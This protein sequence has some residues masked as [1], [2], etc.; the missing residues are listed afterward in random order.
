MI[1]ILFGIWLH[2]LKQS[3]REFCGEQ[4]LFLPQPIKRFEKASKVSF[5]L[6]GE[7]EFKKKRKRGQA[8][9]GRPA[10][11]SAQPDSVVHFPSLLSPA[12]GGRLAP[13]DAGHVA[14]IRRRWTRRGRPAITWSE[15][16]PVPPGST[17]S[18]R[19]S[20]LLPLSLASVAAVAAPP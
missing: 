8:L 20:L 10:S 15:G 17:L 9:L 4:F 14:A 12:R 2:L 19:S 1:Q 3:C 6:F 7:K 18:P 11:L 13:P 5:K 16:R